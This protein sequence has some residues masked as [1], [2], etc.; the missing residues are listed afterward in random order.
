MVRCKTLRRPGAKMPATA[1]MPLTTGNHS[2][3]YAA[4][5]GAGGIQGSPLK[6]RTSASRAGTSFLRVV[7]RQLR[8]RAKRVAPAWLLTSGAPS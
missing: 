8:T 4:A 2:P 6:S 5:S 1:S 7:D 3:R